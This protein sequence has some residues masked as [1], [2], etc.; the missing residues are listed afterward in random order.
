ME[1]HQRTFRRNR[2]T[3]DSVI[4]FLSN[5]ADYKGIDPQEMKELADQFNKEIV[6]DR[7]R[8]EI[9]GQKRVTQWSTI[10]RKPLLYTR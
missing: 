4:F 8:Y 1:R 3:V 6:A 5:Q 7:A 9:A 10:T 2:F